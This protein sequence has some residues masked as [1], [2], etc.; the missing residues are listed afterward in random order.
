MEITKVKQS[1]PELKG[2]LSYRK[3]LKDFYNF[4][5]SMNPA[6]SFRRFAQIAGFKSPNYLQWIIEGKRNLTEKTAEDLAEKFK[7]SKADAQ[8]FVSLVRLEH[9][10]SDEDKRE[11]ER[12]RLIS[13]KRA[14]AKEIPS[15]QTQVLSEWHHLLVRELFIVERKSYSG[16]WIAKA[17]AG[18]ITAEQAEASVKLLLKAGFLKFENKKYKVTDPVVDTNDEHFQHVFMQKHHSALLKSWAQNLEKLVPSQQ[19]LGVLNIPL[20]AKKIPDLRR[21]IRQFQDEILGLVQEETDPDCL[22]Q[23]GTYLMPYPKFD[24]K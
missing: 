8:L 16:E 23:L 15:A 13:I 3:Y 10:N 21:R 7:F 1:A 20:N 5:K 4:K 19:E 18:L 6:F 11:A 9:A 17:L 12:L 14:V 22:V 2:Y 24:E